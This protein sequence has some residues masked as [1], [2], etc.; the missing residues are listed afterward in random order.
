M[1]EDTA[2]ELNPELTPASRKL[3][4]RFRLLTVAGLLLAMLAASFIAG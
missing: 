3:F 4:G 1:N 2:L